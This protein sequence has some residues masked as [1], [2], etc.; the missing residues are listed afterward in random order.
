[1]KEWSERVIVQS[2]RQSL[3]HSL[4]H[5]IDSNELTIEFQ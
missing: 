2:S 4:H 5:R 1:M 3:R